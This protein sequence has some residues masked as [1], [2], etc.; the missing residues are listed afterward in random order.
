MQRVEQTRAAKWD[1]I[2]YPPIDQL[3]SNNFPAVTSTLDVPVAD[4]NVVY[5]T[6]V[7]TIATVSTNP[8]LKMIRVD[9]IWSLM[10]RGPFTNTVV[11]YR[12]PD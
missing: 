7:T 10:K 3:V 12:S 5:A 1:M 11:T 8:P 4:T 2:A 9:C 6:S